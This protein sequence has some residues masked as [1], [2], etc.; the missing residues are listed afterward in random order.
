MI[1]NFQK[2]ISEEGYKGMLEKLSL[3]K[4]AVKSN[5]GIFSDKLQMNS[6][7]KG[8]DRKKL[9]RDL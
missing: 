2:D 6:L 4:E 5:F 8:I 9:I 3:Y 7:A 1:S